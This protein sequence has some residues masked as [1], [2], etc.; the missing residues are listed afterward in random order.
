MAAFT[1]IATGIGLAMN[2]GSTAASF[3]QADKQ[4]DAAQAAAAEADKAMEEARK[5]LSVNYL[6]G[7]SINKEAYE[8]EREAFL[9]GAQQI[10]QAGKEG[11]SRGAA[12]T[13][14]KALAASQKA[15]QGSR[16]GMTEDLLTLQ[17]LAAKEDARLAGE[18]ATIETKTA[19]GFEK[20]AADAR[21]AAS[22]ATQQAATGLV[23]IG[24]QALK[25]PGLYG[26]TDV[27]MVNDLALQQQLVP[28]GGVINSDASLDL[29]NTIFD[30][31][32]LDALTTY[33]EERLV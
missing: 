28:P 16:I 1:T 31:R 2:V 8:L 13:A 29:N 19:E 9:S 17:K 30:Q 18:R 33:N 24:T 3:V 12:V 22:A 23:N 26:K 14:G 27:P 21:A 11:E 4:R 15:Q 5:Q 6:E 32:Y 10:V 25:L 20:E 7:L